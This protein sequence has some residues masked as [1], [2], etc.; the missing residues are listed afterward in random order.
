MEKKYTLQ[1]EMTDKGGEWYLDI[2][3]P[4]GQSLS[5]QDAATLLTTA[6]TICVKASENPKEI[7][8]NVIGQIDTEFSKFNI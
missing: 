6:I 8:D 2:R 4:D 7:I 3:Q 5:I 1:I